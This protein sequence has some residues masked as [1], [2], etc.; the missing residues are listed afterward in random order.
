MPQVEQSIEVDVPL[1]IAYAQWTQFETFPH[2]LGCVEKITRL[3]N[4]LTRW[5]TKV[6][7]VERE[8]EAEIIEQIPD[9]SV[10]WKT[11][12]GEAKQTGVVTFH[13]LADNKTKVVLALHYERKGFAQN[14]GDRLGFIKRQVA[15]DLKT[16]KQYIEARDAEAVSRSDRA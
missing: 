6:A 8:F 13:R 4:S 3:D 2:F 11:V 7:G 12:D 10:A 1:R 15:D 5:K 9:E 16:F 14:F